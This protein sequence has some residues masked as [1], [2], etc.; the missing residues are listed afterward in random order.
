MLL[1]AI[2]GFAS[3]PCPWQAPN[4]AACSRWEELMQRLESA[5]QRAEAA[6][7]RLEAMAGTKSP[8]TAEAIGPEES[9]V[10]AII[11]HFLNNVA[12]P[13]ADTG[14]FE[15]DQQY[16]LTHEG[17]VYTTQ[18][19]KAAWVMGTSRVDF[20]P[21]TFR[22]QPRNEGLATVNFNLGDII[23]LRDHGQVT[24]R[25]LL[26][27]QEHQG[28]WDDVLQNFALV[29]W[30]FGRL[31]L[32]V[33][34]TP[35]SLG[36]DSAAFNQ[37]LSRGADNTWS[38]RETLE[39]ADLSVQMKETALST[40]RITGQIRWDGRDYEKL[41]VLSNE[42]STAQQNLDAGGSTQKLIARLD[43]LYDIFTRFD[44]S[45]VATD[46][47]A[48]N[49]QG[50]IANIERITLG[51]G[52]NALSSN[53]A[54]GDGKGSTLNLQ[55]ELAGIQTHAADLPAGL[56]PTAGR[57]EMGLFNIPPRLLS[58][59]LKISLASEQLPED[60]QEGYLDQAF[61]TLF[62]NSGLGLYLKDSFIMAPNARLELGA[63]ATVNPRAAL[64]G[65]GEFNLR[66]EG[67][68]KILDGTGKLIDKE[69]VG[70]FL[71]ILMA[72]SNRTQ[73]TGKVIDSFALRLGEDGKLWLNGKDV[74]ALFMPSEAPSPR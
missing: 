12:L 10:R 27:E 19:S 71:A 37:V 49:A 13:L 29:T 42:L 24:A 3:E 62:L 34:N 26:G 52:F 22:I 74:T 59:I 36:L 58:E 64:G 14:S 45:L 21:L 38:Q 65:S 9:R 11:A 23:T 15:I 30:R 17:D 20:G 61:A 5:A 4:S 43:K 70:P 7:N 39:L 53:P 57:L 35:I 63:R 47:Q 8:T 44:S 48:S 28:I 16:H 40:G 41:L 50:P 2:V 51:N 25:L 66:I 56:S 67:L 69:T 72:L 32:V 31:N 68:E 73:Q 54:Q 6:A 1:T 33:S 18:L 46:L 55:L 60:Q